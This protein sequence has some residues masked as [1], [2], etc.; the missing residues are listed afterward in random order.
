MNSEEAQER[1]FVACELTESQ[2]QGLTCV[3]C[4]SDRSFV[5][6]PAGRTDEGDQVFRCEECNGDE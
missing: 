3:Y 5:M 2:V 6:V 1:V 4:R